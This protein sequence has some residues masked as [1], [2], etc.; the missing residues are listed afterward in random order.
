M[1]QSMMREEIIAYCD[2]LPGARRDNPFGAGLTCW[3]VGSRA[4]ALLADGGEALSLRA[5]GAE[6]AAERLRAAYTG[7][8]PF[9]P[10]DGWI[11]VEISSTSEDVLKRRIRDSHD[12]ALQELPDTERAR[13]AAAD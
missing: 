2:G 3:M 10:H 12:R 7:M 4:F 11:A 5:D 9:L 8:A 6:S 1:T 13:I